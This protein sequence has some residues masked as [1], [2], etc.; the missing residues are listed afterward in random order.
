M[1]ELTLEIIYRH[2]SQFHK[3]ERPVLRIGRALDND[4]ILPDPSVSAYHLLLK[5]NTTGDYELVPLADEN[6]TRIDGVMLDH[7]ISI[8]ELPQTLEI[9]RTRI[10]VHDRQQPVVPAR[11]ISCRNGG[12]CIFGH[13]LPATLLF[14]AM[15]LVSG[16][17]N[18]L[19]THELLSWE[20]FW[21]DQLIIVA[22]ALGF[23]LAMV[24]ITRITSHRWE[25][26]SCLS[27]VSLA[28]VLAFGIDQATAFLDYYFTSPLPGFSLNALWA[29]VA[30]PL[31]TLWF[32]T[33][34]HHGNVAVSAILVVIT[35]T[36][37]AYLQFKKVADHYGLDR[38]FSRKSHYSH[39][40]Y[41][42]DIRAAKTMDIGQFT[43][44]FRNQHKEKQ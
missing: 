17:D 42:R 15:I 27:F 29:A 20:S 39:S 1:A 6:G 11:L 3:V 12:P 35:F 26:A 36:P 14:A 32:L 16:F 43:A 25:F 2:Q 30:I 24:L 19:S 5:R 40:L 34:L 31:F 28:L 21:S 18:Y 7:P 23:T 33:R 41:P 10:I 8:D 9:G 13:W 38:E 22:I 4:I 37:G 44:S